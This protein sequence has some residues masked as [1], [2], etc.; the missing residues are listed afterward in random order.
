MADVEATLTSASGADGLGYRMTKSS[1]TFEGFVKF[2]C[3]GDE[4]ATLD[5]GAGEN[6]VKW[7]LGS[8][9][10]GQKSSVEIPHAQ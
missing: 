5:S 7:C 2:R 4:V 10:V 6:I 3:P 9:H 1:C 8:R